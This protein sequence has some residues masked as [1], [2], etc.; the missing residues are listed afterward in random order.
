MLECLVVPRRPVE[1]AFQERNPGLKRM[2]VGE[3]G[4]G[5]ENDLWERVLPGE[6]ESD[7]SPSGQ[8]WCE[9]LVSVGVED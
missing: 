2:I 6:G 1:L 3:R 4:W 9:P 5:D 7:W 8:R